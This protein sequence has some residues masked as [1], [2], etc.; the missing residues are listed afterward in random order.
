M[1]LCFL[2]F[3]NIIP[4]EVFRKMRLVLNHRTPKK[5]YVFLKIARDPDN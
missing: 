2:K 1:H 5:G 4:L 3:D